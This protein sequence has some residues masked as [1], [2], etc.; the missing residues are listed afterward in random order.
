MGR[1]RLLILGLVLNVAHCLETPGENLDVVIK[2]KQVTGVLGEDVYLDC[3]YLGGSSIIS[4]LWKRQSNSKV[5][6]KRLTGFI[7]DRPFIRDSD[8]SIP[9]SATNLTVKMRVSTVEA[10]GE[11][12]CVFISDEEEFTGS[13][14]LT[15]LVRPDTHIEVNGDIVSGTHYQSVLCSAVNG[16]PVPEI[17]WLIEGTSPSDDSFTVVM[18]KTIHPNGTAVVT[19]IF[20]FPTHLQDEDKVTCVVQHPSLPNPINT[21]VRVETFVF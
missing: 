18:N 19:S 12:T 17:S 5:K 1:S 2:H 14:F 21:T 3:L 15:V 8:F 9:A 11:Y 10:E 16:R 6:T 20:R 4:A 13:I 7:N